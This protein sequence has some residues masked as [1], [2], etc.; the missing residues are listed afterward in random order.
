MNKNELESLKQFCDD[1]WNKVISRPTSTRKL[2][3]KCS[4]CGTHYKSIVRTM[5]RAEKLTGWPCPV[6]ANLV[7]VKGYNDLKTRYP[8][9]ADKLNS[10]L[11]PERIIFSKKTPIE[12]VCDKGHVFNKTIAKMLKDDSCPICHS[13][14]YLSENAQLAN[15]WDSEANIA[16]PDTP[17]SMDGLLVGSNKRV[18]WVCSDCGHKWVNQ[19]FNRGVKHQGCPKCA[20]LRISEKAKARYARKSPLSDYKDVAKYWDTDLNEDA[21]DE[22]SATSPAKRWFICENGHESLRAVRDVVKT[23]FI[24]KACGITDSIINYNDLMAYYDD[25]SHNPKL[26]GTN[27]YYTK[28]HWLCPVCN[29]KF[30]SSVRGMFKRLNDRD[31][32]CPIC[33]R[34]KLV[35][36]IND[37]A[38][39]RPDLTSE[40]VDPAQ[41][42]KVTEYSNDKLE[43]RCMVNPDH[44]PYTTTPK[45]RVN[46]VNCKKCT[47]LRRETAIN[48]TRLKKGH[49]D[50]IPDWIMDYAI[51]EDRERM[52]DKGMSAGSPENITII[53]PNCGHERSTTICN[54]G[55]SPECPICAY[56]MH[57]S[58]GQDELTEWLRS[59]LGH[60]AVRSNQSGLLDGRKELDI[61]VPSMKM[62]IEY[63][64]L[65]W[66][67]EENVG[68][69]STYDKWKTCKDNGIHLL[70]IWDDDWNYRKELVKRT[71]KTILLGRPK[72]H[73]SFK[74]YIYPDKSLANAFMAKE[75]LGH[76][77]DA[78][79]RIAIIGK[80]HRFLAMMVG[81]M[82]NKRTFKISAYANVYSDDWFLSDLLNKIKTDLNPSRIMVDLDHCLYDGNELNKFG[83]VTYA[84]TEP[85]SFLSNGYMVRHY[86][87]HS[88]EGFYRVYDAGHV[89]LILSIPHR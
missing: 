82:D 30:V 67:N 51:P 7:L 45:Q 35:P 83:F 15:E 57:M 39:T 31:T 50:P 18:H 20:N 2:K 42:K 64:G 80:D 46:G 72:R 8:N 12:F 3:W 14:G 84:E 10:G 5:L 71:I 65:Y 48:K 47:A 74:S 58:K 68:K 27:N 13:G 26:I 81:S 37:L 63:N 55:R 24:C 6:C 16:D 69:N 44:T 75:Y 38:T 22:I 53:Y 21:P 89:T 60:D 88:M 78:P 41:A 32:M 76:Y 86:D 36:G 17:D 66:H 40:L 79:Y 85:S 19:I 23:G 87:T 25:N 62:A 34:Y 9:I 56:G 1:D 61:Y 29:Q 59:I 43:W 33:G 54:M 4:R 77:K 11:D 28:L 73:D 52:I 49:S 70:T